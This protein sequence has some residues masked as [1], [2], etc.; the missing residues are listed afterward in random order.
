MRRLPTCIGGG[1]NILLPGRLPPGAPDAL[2]PL[3][4]EG[5]AARHGLWRASGSG[6]EHVGI[7]VARYR[8]AMVI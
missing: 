6:P 5:W 2:V 8:Y 4:D 3:Q 1:M 7:D